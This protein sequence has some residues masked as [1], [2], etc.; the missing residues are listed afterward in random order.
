MNVLIL[1]PD[2]VG[3]T[4]LQR[5]ITVHLQ[6]NEL[7][8]PVINLHELTNG[9][10][11]YWSPE[12]N[13][14]IVSKRAVPTWG[15]FQSLQQVVELLASVDHYKVSRL[16]HYH[17]INRGDNLEQ[18]VQFYDYLNKNF[19]IIACRR[20][21]V[22]EHALSLAMARATNKLN[23]Y[24][25]LEKIETFADIYQ[26][27]IHLDL[28]AFVKC[29]DAYRSYL[30]WSTRYFNPTSYF[31]YE[32]DLPR[33][34]EFISHLPIRSAQPSRVTW[35]DAFG[36]DFNTYN[37]CHYLHSDIG[38][39]YLTHSDGTMPVLEAALSDQD[40]LAIYQQHSPEHWPAVTSS[41]DL[42]HL[43][44]DIKRAFH[45]ICQAQSMNSVAL[46]LDADSR[47]YVARYHDQ[48]QTANEA[49]KRMVEL[50]IL[51]SGPPIKKQTLSEKRSMISNFDQC[52]DTY[53]DWIMHN[54][55]IAQPIDK[56]TIDQQCQHQREFWSV[57]PVRDLSTQD[58]PRVGQS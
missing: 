40:R 6:L 4:L 41:Q 37:R 32:H 52:V 45:A 29:L 54:P 43:P 39:I 31:N 14:E 36:I 51:V 33:I 10:G 50:D 3:S 42:N 24:S 38:S 8:R 11:R 53:N 21:N 46:W 35:Q 57:N 7:D 20:E 17:I 12:F 49:I 5:L 15:Y 55:D 18:Q 26:H 34:E 2:A 22:F 23:V 58:L 27:K 9:L 28:V 19:F 25:T 44:V 56:D 47:S 13:R 1:T 48:Y 30:D 16:A